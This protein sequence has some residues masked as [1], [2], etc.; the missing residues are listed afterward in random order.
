MNK[1]FVVEK[2]SSQWK[3]TRTDGWCIT[4]IARDLDTGNSYK[5]Y[6]DTSFKSY[7]A[8]RK[9][10]VNDKF[11][12]VNILNEQKKI[13]SSSNMPRVIKKVYEKQLSLL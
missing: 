12:N 9:L 10:K 1:V 11:T 8:W 13:M 3:S 6:P 5:T 2:I 4:V 7:Q